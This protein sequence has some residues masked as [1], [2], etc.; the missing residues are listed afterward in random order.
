MG[1]LG[2]SLRVCQ[3]EF[4]KEAI[5]NVVYRQHP[6]IYQKKP[7]IVKI[8]RSIYSLFADRFGRPLRFPPRI[9]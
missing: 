8:K 4:D 7:K 1:R 5:Y 9:L 2:H 6:V 3:L